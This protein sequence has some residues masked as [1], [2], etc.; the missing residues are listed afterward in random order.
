ME[1]KKKVN[2]LFLFRTLSLPGCQEIMIFR[3]FS[4]LHNGEEFFWLAMMIILCL[5]TGM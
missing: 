4:L 3:W 1:R 2:L 5:N